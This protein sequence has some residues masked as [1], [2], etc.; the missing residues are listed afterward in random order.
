MAGLF[1]KLFSG[2]SEPAPEDVLAEQLVHVVQQLK[3]AALFE[4]GLGEELIDTATADEPLTEIEHQEAGLTPAAQMFIVNLIAQSC[5]EQNFTDDEQSLKI[6]LVVL[7]N[8]LNIDGS[9]AADLAIA[10]LQWR[11]AA[12]ADI[13]AMHS[14]AAGELQLGEGD[15]EIFLASGKTALRL[16]EAMEQGPMDASDEEMEYFGGLCVSLAS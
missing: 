12:M 14:D 2:R 4:T 10:G 5:A 11:G 6:I 8:A 1:A 9:D 7:V 13:Q 15:H 3:V 16:V